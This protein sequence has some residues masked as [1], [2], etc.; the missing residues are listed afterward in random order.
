MFECEIC[1][2]K[3]FSEKDYKC[4]M[5]VFTRGKD[6]HRRIFFYLHNWY[7]YVDDEK[8]PDYIKDWEARCRAWN[9]LN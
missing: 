9:P 4:H 3:F 5:F 2:C 8:L 1:G 7:P 6:L